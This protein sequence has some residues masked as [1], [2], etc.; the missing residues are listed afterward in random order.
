MT[1]R[2]TLPRFLDCGETALVVEFADRIDDG[3]ARRVLALDAALAADPP[4]GLVETVPTYRSLMVHYDPLRLSRAALLAH[5]RGLLGRPAAAEPA[6]RL[7]RLPA[8][9]DP[10]LAPDLAHVAAATGLSQAAVVRLHAGAVYRV[11]MFGFAPG[12]AYLSGLPAALTL[13]RRA[14]PRDR[15]GDGS[16]IV[17]GGQAIVA[18][19]A[20]P[21]GWHILGRTAERL[22]APARD[23]VFLLSPGDRLSFDPV[24]AATHAALSARTAAG[25]VVARQVPQ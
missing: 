1:P 20:M 7:W 10:A 12:W 15:I 3:A 13:P 8:C 18:A 9:Y 2:L 4:G 19:L 21:S 24:D 25:E 23:P 17:A 11:A 6:G 14:S 5:L 22:F 16:L